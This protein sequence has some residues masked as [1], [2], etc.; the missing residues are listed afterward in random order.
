V[1]AAHAL[2]A[3]L[4]RRLRATSPDEIRARRVRVPGP[5]KARVVARAVAVGIS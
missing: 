5:A 1:C 4:A 3:E 2:F